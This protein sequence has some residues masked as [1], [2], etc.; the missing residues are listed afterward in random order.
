MERYKIFT[1]L[2]S[3]MTMAVAVVESVALQLQLPWSFVGATQRGPHQRGPPRNGTPYQPNP[4]P[5]PETRFIATKF[6]R[7]DKKFIK[8][9]GEFSLTI[10]SVF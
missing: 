7:Y 3:Q 2:F 6:L 5:H 10:V 8:L 9:L 1:A 4:C